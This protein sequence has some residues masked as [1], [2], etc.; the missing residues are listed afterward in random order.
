MAV[1]AELPVEILQTIFCFLVDSDNGHFKSVVSPDPLRNLLSVSHVCSLWRSAALRAS[2]AWSCVLE[3]SRS[4]SRKPS[5]SFEEVF[6]RSGGATLSIQ[7]ILGRHSPRLTLS[8][9]SEGGTGPGSIADLRWGRVLNEFSG[10]IGLFNVMFGKR[11]PE[12]IELGALREVLGRKAEALK[13]LWIAFDPSILGEEAAVRLSG[14][15]P[16]RVPEDGP[17]ANTNN[18]LFPTAAIPAELTAATPPTV[19]DAATAHQHPAWTLFSGHAPHLQRIHLQ[20]CL[21]DFHPSV[22]PPHIFANLTVFQL[23][24]MRNLPAGVAYTLNQ[25]TLL[26]HDHH[27]DGEGG[28]LT[29]DYSWIEVFKA[30]PQLESLHLV[31]VP[32]EVRNPTVTGGASGNT[33]SESGDREVVKFG[34]LKDL[35]IVS[36]STMMDYLTKRI[37]IPSAPSSSSPSESSS[38]LISGDGY[39]IPGVPEPRYHLS[40]NLTLPPQPA[41]LRTYAASFVEEK[42]RGR[43][44]GVKEF[45]FK[46]G[47]SSLSIVAFHYDEGRSGLPKAKRKKRGRG[48][49]NATVSIEGGSDRVDAQEGYQ[50]GSGSEEDVDAERQR[51]LPANQRL[52][53]TFYH[54]DVGIDL[55]GKYT[56][57]TQLSFSFARGLSILSQ[58]ALPDFLSSLSSSSS[59]STSGI[60]AMLKNVWKVN[61]EV[62]CRVAGF[63]Y[64]NNTAVSNIELFNNSLVS[65][66]SLFVRAKRL[67]LSE[68]ETIKK[69]VIPI[70]QAYPPVIASERERQLYYCY[71]HTERKKDTTL[72]PILFPNVT[73][74]EVC[75]ECLEDDAVVATLEA[76]EIWRKEM[77]RAVSTI[78]IRKVNPS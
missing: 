33:T 53:G 14:P 29:V 7:A 5:G 69:I 72:L 47:K 34:K 67:V 16:A 55:S 6:K 59:N 26:P 1:P 61:L 36:Y 24:I 37:E 57:R 18:P 40:L 64:V 23:I 9:P 77:G 58:Q 56:S 31:G 76:Y 75:E 3:L 15:R 8:L 39:G 70:L 78:A 51:R 42:F 19:L 30:M 41:L 2:P 49:G 65:L 21:L 45:K 20:N 32:P 13:S 48:G 27:D 25:T 38:P 46:I 12:D 4:A 74:I 54:P 73:V 11:M 68:E 35:A 63:N 50:T 66:L 28:V 60:V 52:V 17:D 44:G 62:L 71:S 43:T 10:R 22:S